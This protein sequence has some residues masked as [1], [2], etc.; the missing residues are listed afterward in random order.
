MS[1]FSP[2]S[3]F[4]RESHTMPREVSDEL[5][6]RH[7]AEDEYRVEVTKAKRASVR[8]LDLMA[9]CDERLD[10][11]G[12]ERVREMLTEF[13]RKVEDILDTIN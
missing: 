10:I 6:A 7:A 11:E 4:D 9:D 13:R 12:D 3:H 8:L 5:R 2:R 1:E